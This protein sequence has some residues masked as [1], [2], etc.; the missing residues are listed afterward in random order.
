[1]SEVITRAAAERQV[2]VVAIRW[3]VAVSRRS[4]NASTLDVF[5]LFG[6]SFTLKAIVKYL[7]VVYLTTILREYR[8]KTIS[9]IS[10]FS[11]C[12]GMLLEGLVLYRRKLSAVLIQLWLNL[13]G[14]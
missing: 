4:E 7:G 10:L 5:T 9:S 6:K 8:T 3:I 11:G 12:V 2:G 1:M 14:S 13:H